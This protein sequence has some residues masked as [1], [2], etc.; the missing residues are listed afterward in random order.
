M[1]F[2]SDPA[3]C[4]RI[5]DLLRLQCF[6]RHVSSESRLNGCPQLFLYQGRGFSLTLNVSEMHQQFRGSASL[7]SKRA[8]WPFVKKVKPGL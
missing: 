2:E 3:K 1:E 4:R 7:T 8:I 5:T 6:E